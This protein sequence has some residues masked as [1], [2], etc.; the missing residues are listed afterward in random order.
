MHVIRSRTPYTGLGDECQMK[1]FNKKISNIR[2]AYLFGVLVLLVIGLLIIQLYSYFRETAP[3][4]LNNYEVAQP[5]GF[6]ILNDPALEFMLEYPSSWILMSLPYGDHGDLTAKYDITTATGLSIGIY[7]MGASDPAGLVQKIEE[8][9]T[10]TQKRNSQIRR[11]ITYD[12]I[13]EEH[14]KFHTATALMRKYRSTNVGQSFFDTIFGAREPDIIIE[15]AFA[16]QQ[17]TYI[18]SLIA[19]ESAYP[20]IQEIFEYVINSIKLRSE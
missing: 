20:K 17:K 8:K 18:V 13:S 16:T 3:S 5:V 19:P 4:F 15:A 7:D 11:V 10:A 14:R 6:S 1:A 12:L 9:H 2:W